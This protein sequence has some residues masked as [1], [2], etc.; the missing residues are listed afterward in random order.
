MKLSVWSPVINICV[1]QDLMEIHDG[2]L[3]WQHETYPLYIL[4]K[5]LQ[6]LQGPPCLIVKV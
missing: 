3:I 4:H 5:E 6:H 2:L 1:S